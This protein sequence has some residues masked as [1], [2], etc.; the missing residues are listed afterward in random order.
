ML[1]SDA[2]SADLVDLR[3]LKVQ[4]NGNINTTIS[5]LYKYKNK[6]E[7]NLFIGNIPLDKYHHTR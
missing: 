4:R 3:E 1:N 6:H 7:E 5:V 2:S